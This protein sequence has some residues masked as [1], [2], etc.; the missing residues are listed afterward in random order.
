MHGVDV[1]ASFHD[2]RDGIGGTGS[3]DQRAL[4]TRFAHTW[5]SMA[6]TG[7]PNNPRIPNWP[8][9]D[10]ATRATMIF[11]RE[12]RVENDPR[13]EIRTFWAEISA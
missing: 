5:V 12:L 3:P 7:N 2:Y 1:A 13:G 8:A 4:W 9:Y 11:D 10:A 6:K